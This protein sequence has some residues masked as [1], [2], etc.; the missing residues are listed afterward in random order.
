MKRAAQHKKASFSKSN[1]LKSTYESKCK[2]A[3]RA[4]E[5]NSRLHSN[6]QAK[7]KELS[8]SARKMEVCN[9]SP[10]HTSSHVI[11]FLLAYSP[12]IFRLFNMFV[13]NQTSI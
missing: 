2:D 5:N 10:E 1:G 8:Q 4:D 12:L 3:D 9:C 11:P 7:A 13:G 6:P